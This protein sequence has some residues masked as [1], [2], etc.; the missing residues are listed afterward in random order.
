MGPLALVE[1]AVHTGRYAEAA[2]HV[3]AIRESNIAELSSRYAL[4]GMAVQV[5][6][7]SRRTACGRISRS[8]KRKKPSWSGPIWWMYTCSKPALAYS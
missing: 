2:A 8:Q 3:G 7:F 6:P 4:L 1:A 5:P